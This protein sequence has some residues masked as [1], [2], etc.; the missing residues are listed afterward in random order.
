MIIVREI[1]WYNVR[2]IVRKYWHYILRKLVLSKRMLNTFLF[3]NV[4]ACFPILFFLS[5]KSLMKPH[6]SKND[7][8]NSTQSCCK[9]FVTPCCKFYMMVTM[10]QGEPLS[11]AH[12][13]NGWSCPSA[14]SG[15]DRNAGQKVSLYCGVKNISQSTFILSGKTFSF[16]TKSITFDEFR[17]GLHSF[18]SF[19]FG[20]FWAVFP[21]FLLKSFWR[22]SFFFCFLI[23]VLV[24]RSPFNS[25]YVRGFYLDFQHAL[26]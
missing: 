21:S 13:H 6:C 15:K 12:L 14:A 18:W 22:S 20:F 24:F 1:M 23:Q 8:S 3:S 9:D 16:W 11:F 4:P 5:S 26:P 7:W 2:D 17:W 25:R 19:K 10:A